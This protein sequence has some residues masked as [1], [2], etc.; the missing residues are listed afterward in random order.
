MKATRCSANAVS[1]RQGTKKQLVGKP[2]NT[3]PKKFFSPENFLFSRYSFEWNW[4]KSF[5]AQPETQM[6]KEILL[7]FLSRYKTQAFSRSM[8]VAVNYRRGIE[9]LIEK[10]LRLMRILTS[11]PIY[12][13]QLQSNT[14]LSL[15]QSKKPMDLKNVLLEKDRQ[16]CEARWAVGNVEFVP[17]KLKTNS[18]FQPKLAEKSFGKHTTSRIELIGV[19]STSAQTLAF[20]SSL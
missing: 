19:P 12:D 16:I 1:E 15:Q 11:H 2:K 4:S 10:A 9:R 20:P 3:I 5:F 6:N 7:K 8:R 14:S 13:F 18:F 17:T